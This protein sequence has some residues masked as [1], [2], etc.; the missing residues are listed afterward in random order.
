MGSLSAQLS[1]QNLAFRSTIWKYFDSSQGTY[2]DAR[3]AD[4]ETLVEILVGHCTKFTRIYLVLDAVDECPNHGRPSYR[5]LLLDSL[6]KIQQMGLGQIQILCT[7]RPTMD[8]Q[9]AFAGTPTIPVLSGFNSADIKLYFEVEIERKIREKPRWLGEEKP[10]RVLKE[11][12][13]SR[14]VDKANGM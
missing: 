7:S 2:E 11:R 1:Q 13:V 4:P 3:N 10:G 5:S 14:L 12:I 8:I 9:E 6:K